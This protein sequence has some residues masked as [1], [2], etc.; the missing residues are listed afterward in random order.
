[1]A[2][3]YHVVVWIDHKQARVFHFSA[4][5]AEKVVIHP[6]RPI[7]D[8]HRKRRSDGNHDT[9]DQAFLEDVTKAISDAGALLVVGPANEKH[10]LMKHIERKHPSLK[11]KVE[12]VEAADHPSDGELLAHARKFMAAADRM[13]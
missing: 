4:D 5:E 1:M 11:A 8:Y 12:A 6:D 7:K 10:E 2:D 13:R 3:H 9:E